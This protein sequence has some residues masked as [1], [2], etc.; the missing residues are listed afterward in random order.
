MDYFA[1][2]ITHNG[3]NSDLL[4]YAEGDQYYVPRNFFM[5]HLVRD[6]D[7]GSYLC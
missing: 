5:P 4:L 3:I 7:N 1:Y 6:G 2:V